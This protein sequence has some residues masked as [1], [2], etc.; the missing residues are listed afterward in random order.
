MLPRLQHSQLQPMAA[1]QSAPFPST[2]LAM[3]P[4]VS[5]TVD[6]KAAPPPKKLSAR[7]APYSPSTRTPS[8]A[9]DELKLDSPAF[10]TRRKSLEG[11]KKMKEEVSKLAD[12]EAKAAAAWWINKLQ[13]KGVHPQTRKVF[14]ENFVEEVFNRCA[15]HWYPTDPKRGSGYRSVIS[16]AHIDPILLK[17]CH[18]ARL[19]PAVLPREFVQLISPGEVRV[20]HVLNEY[21]EEVV[22]SGAATLVDDH[23]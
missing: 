13:L 12:R 3:P 6:I 21:H 18:A 11:H 8:S 4:S 16:D 9:F 2:T 23:V 15:G 7:A 1:L 14:E 20:R 19:D 10:N 5:L 17:A 22:Y